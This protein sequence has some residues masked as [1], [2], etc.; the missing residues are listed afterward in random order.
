MPSRGI[1]VTGNGSGAPSSTNGTTAGHRTVS[2][3][4]EKNGTPFRLSKTELRKALLMYRMCNGGCAGGCRKR[5]E[6]ERRLAEE[7]RKRILLKLN[8]MAKCLS[9]LVATVN[10]KLTDPLLREQMNEAVRILTELRSSI[11]SRSQLV[12][13]VSVNGVECNRNLHVSSGNL[14]TSKEFAAGVP[15]VAPLNDGN[16]GSAKKRRS[17][18]LVVNVEE[19]KKKR[20]S[21]DD[22]IVL[23]SDDDEHT[24]ESSN[25]ATAPPGIANEDSADDI[26]ILSD[27]ENERSQT[28]RNAENDHPSA[29]NAMMVIKLQ[30]SNHE[31]SGCLLR[32]HPLFL[33]SIN[34]S[35]N[36]PRLTISLGNTSQDII[37]CRRV[38]LDVTYEI[39]SVNQKLCVYYYLRSIAESD[40]NYDWQYAT[41]VPCNLRKR[42]QLLFAFDHRQSFT[43]EV[44]YVV[45][46][47][48][49]NGKRGQWSDICVV[50][51]GLCARLHSC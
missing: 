38:L 6:Q 9:C 33:P 24:P 14:P 49:G 3:M 1:G 45:G 48:E 41:C 44:L 13:R 43:Q 16:A 17:E 2:D 35:S 20:S 29:T 36:L 34:M 46:Y 31:W 50:N 12:G 42:S 19:A 4:E 30:Y 25:S 28:G 10:D 22:A 47:L 7:E 27:G 40:P 23:L 26:T 15:K 18:R 21:E 5:E 11:A 51:L 8:E 32:G 39:R 37:S